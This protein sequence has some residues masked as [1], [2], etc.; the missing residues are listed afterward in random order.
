MSAAPVTK[1]L[2]L[3]ESANTIW[4][5]PRCCV[6]VT[7]DARR[8]TVGG[9]VVATVG[10]KDTALRNV[11]IVGIAAEPDVHLGQLA[12]AF[13]VVPETVRLL[14]QLNV[15]EGFEA[16]LERKHGGMEPTKRA[17]VEDRVR[18]LFDAGHTIEEAH[19]TVRKR[20]GKSTVARIRKDWAAEKQA[21]APTSHPEDA[22]ERDGASPPE[23]EA[24]PA[25]VVAATM[26]PV[27][28]GG[29]T[30]REPATTPLMQHAGTWLLIATVNALGLHARA[31]AAAGE[32]VSGSA[33]RLALDAVVAAFALGERAVEGVRRLA[34]SS[35]GA[36][37]LAAR[38]PSPEWTRRTLCRF[39]ED[40]GSA[41]L[42]F[43]M[44]RAYLQTARAEGGGEGPVFYVDNHLRPY[45]GKH[46]VRKGWRMQDKRV[47]PGATDYYLHDEDGRPV[48]RITAPHHGALTDFLSP[49]TALI[50][51][52]LPDETSLVA[53]DRAGA[54]PEQ[55]AALREAN[56]E[57]V[58]YE[59][60]PYA[61]LAKSEF[62][63]ELELDGERLRWC[64]TRKNLG[65]GR[66]RVRRICVR[67]EEGRQVNLVAHSVRPA[68]RLIEVMRGR[69]VQENGFKHGNERWGFNHLDGRAVTPFSPGTVIP[70]PARRRLDR[71]LRLW[72]A[73]E[74]EARRALA[75]LSVNDPRRVRAEHDLNQALAEQ[76]RLEALR[77]A[78]PAHAPLG[79]T[80]LAGKLVHHQVAYKLA[81]DAIRIACANA[82][83]ELAAGLAPLLPRPAEAKKVLANLFA[84][85]A[86]IHVTAKAITVTLKAAGTRREMEAVSAFLRGLDQRQ[87]SLPA[88]QAT[89]P[90]RLRLSQIQ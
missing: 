72:R 54:F 80:E 6:V 10:P 8:V 77:P 68:P 31:T 41:A 38:T 5:A 66:G 71:A 14:R 33:L 3:E 62:T 85:P 88:D 46:V 40:A 4:F 76:R 49:V 26:E 34:T 57:F 56:F 18:K 52:A 60:R 75:R 79:E 81:L 53:F 45:T 13:G 55:M 78:T 27:P 9:I 39:S 73:S 90:L 36:L 50:R 64:E 16:L 84:A 37:L 20:V 69:W 65:A 63:Q 48:G 67:T 2:A 70:N 47:R 83:S 29:L 28:D 19:A 82:E 59:R 15:E 89:R 11:L 51:A 87:L 44:A 58:T 22:T 43:G 7:G 24:A 17:A 12:R 23:V 1:E 61:L 35:G 30:A 32:R 74:G 42:H 86:R 21:S 25:L